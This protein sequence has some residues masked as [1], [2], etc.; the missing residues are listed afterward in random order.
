M[1]Q[2]SLQLKKNNR[3]MKKINLKT[4]IVLMLF[5]VIFISNT[6]AQI[7]FNDKYFS[8]SSNYRPK[9][10]RWYYENVVDSSKTE[11][12]EN[13]NMII[14]DSHLLP[15]S[16]GNEL[17][18]FRKSI[19]VDESEYKIM[20]YDGSYNYKVIIDFRKAFVSK[21]INRFV[22]YYDDDYRKCHLTYTVTISSDTV[23]KK[24]FL[25]KYDVYRT[26]LSFQGSSEIKLNYPTK[27]DS[28]KKID[29]EVDVKKFEQYVDWVEGLGIVRIVFKYKEKIYWD[30][31]ISHL[32]AFFGPKK[33][34]KVDSLPDSLLNAYYLPDSLKW[35]VFQQNSYSFRREQFYSS[36]LSG[37]YVRIPTAFEISKDSDT[38]KIYLLNQKN[39]ILPQFGVYTFFNVQSDW[40][41]VYKSQDTLLH[42]IK[43]TV[44]LEIGKNLYLEEFRGA[45]K[46]FNVPGATF[47]EW[48]KHT[49]ILKHTPL[50][51]ERKAYLNKYDVLTIKIEP[52]IINKQYYLGRYFRFEEW[53]SMD[54]D[55]I[56]HYYE[57]IYSRGLN[58]TS[59]YYPR[60][61]HLSKKYYYMKFAKEV[62][63]VALEEYSGDT[64][65]RSF[66][67]EYITYP[68]L[69]MPKTPIDQVPEEQLF[70]LWHPPKE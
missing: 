31:Q 44:K 41:M 52:Q 15:I 11:T 46:A 39:Y 16:W 18:P 26:K 12:H 32:S 48:H 7:V 34:L 4:V 45:I 5:S 56:N 70:I 61:V 9:Y 55:S 3:L 69:R 27:Y 58:D 19:S 59:Y 25:G 60:G 65:I 50:Y 28:L 57:S 10:F 62:G 23:F 49:I 33:F 36:S 47:Y 67:L 13:K 53:T 40:Y 54:N 35:D 42:V 14:I 21:I 30:Y 6:S 66:N 20:N 8:D 17:L 63:L 43:D 1:T 68:I 51:W 38:S 64:L 2:Q 24:Q 37:H 22:D 29:E